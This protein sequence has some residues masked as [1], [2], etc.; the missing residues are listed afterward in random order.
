MIL[1]RDLKRDQNHDYFKYLQMTI[2][3]VS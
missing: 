1:K 2:N 3:K